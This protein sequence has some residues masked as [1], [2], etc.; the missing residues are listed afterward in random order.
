MKAK[1]IYGTNS[2]GTKVLSEFI[3][4]LL[5]KSGWSVKLQSAESAEP[6]DIKD[7]DLVIFGSC[8]WGVPTKSGYLDGQLQQHFRS[9]EHKL[10]GHSFKGQK[11][12]V[13]GLGDSTMYRNFA[14]ASEHL[15]KIVE[16]LKGNLIIEPL[17]VD[18]YFF[19]PKANQKIVRQWT[20]TLL[21]K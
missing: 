18:N 19:E 2:G 16:H 5:K 17:K 6:E 9:F 1:I 11:F 4:E 14:A 3:A 15:E 21:K 8:T 7:N 12:A 20:D 13:F 10:H